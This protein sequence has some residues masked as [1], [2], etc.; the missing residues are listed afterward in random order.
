MAPHPKYTRWVM[1]KKKSNTLT[2]HKGTFL[3]RETS[4]QC[5][6]FVFSLTFSYR[7]M[8]ICLN[9]CFAYVL[10]WLSWCLGSLLHVCCL[11]I[12]A[13]IGPNFNMDGRALPLFICSR[14]ITLT[15]EGR[16]YNTRCSLKFQRSFTRPSRSTGISS[17]LLGDS[18]G[19]IFQLQVDHLSWGL[20][21]AGF[22]ISL[23]SFIIHF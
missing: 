13:T 15:R 19:F 8:R 3:F 17:L 7:R 10:S 4:Y 20:T 5:G 16:L 21:K 22:Q 23:A 18:K 1:M 9:C 12:N 6:A 2:H 14:A 11:L